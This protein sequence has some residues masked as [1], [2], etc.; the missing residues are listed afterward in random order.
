VER[1]RTLAR[2][3]RRPQAGRRAARIP[4]SRCR[5][6]AGYS[7][8]MPTPRPHLARVLAGALLALALDVA[9]LAAGLGGLAPLWRDGHARGLLLVWAAGGGALALLRP[10]RGQDVATA[11]RDPGSML[12]L[13]VV[14]LVTPMVGALGGRLHWLALRPA[15]PIGW[16][17]VG[18]AALGL[19]LRIWAMAVLGPRFSPLVAVQ[20]EHALETRGP[21]ALVRHPGYLGAL[22]A[23]L[24]GAL[25][26][27]SGAALPLWLVMLAA[28]LARV[29]REE[30][31]LAEHFGAPW[32]A[33]AA[34][35]G[36]LLPGLG[37]AR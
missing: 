31:L 19:A 11:R 24:G 10:V 6:P 5:K 34:R 15:N 27:G 35:T 21:Y 32:R 23:C 37:R 2:A 30:A 1:P 26:F 29:R 18:L 4:G 13:F 36:A 8:A 3:R 14:P 22:L 25:A 9:L 20:R 7:A 12:V 17:G 16:A 33:Y 28:Q